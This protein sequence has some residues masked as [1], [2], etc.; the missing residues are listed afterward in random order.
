MLNTLEKFQELFIHVKKYYPCNAA[1]DKETCG[2]Q[3]NKRWPFKLKCLGAEII[4]LPNFSIMS[5]TE[6]S[7][8][9]TCVMGLW[10]I[11]LYIHRRMHRYTHPPESPRN[12][13]FFT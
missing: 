13:L 10:V 11:C 4:Y 12:V 6:I 3:L 8:R 1:K 5:T 2:G 7:R 9:N